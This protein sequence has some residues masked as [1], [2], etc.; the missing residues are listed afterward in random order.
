MFTGATMVDL[1][2][3]VL[4]LGG[5][6]AGILYALQANRRAEEIDRRLRKVEKRCATISDKKLTTG[7]E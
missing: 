4:V 7:N 1:L 2:I 5:F 6:V 3:T